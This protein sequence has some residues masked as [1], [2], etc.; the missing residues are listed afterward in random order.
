MSS[1]DPSIV[2]QAAEKKLAA[3]DLSGG[4]ELFQTSLFNWIDDV[5]FSSTIDK[6][7]LK[8]AV[9][10]LWV[11]Y[12][13]YLSKAK[14][15][16]SAINAFEDALKCPVGG[17]VGRVWLEYARFLEERGKLV[18]A[19]K[20]YLRALVDDGGAVTDEQDRNLLWQEFLEMM[21]TSKPD[22][23]MER[24]KQGIA[25][26]HGG[27]QPQSVTSAA[28]ADE[29]DVYGDLMPDAK[30]QRTGSPKIKQEDPNE[31]AQV[32]RTHVV[33][34]SDVK[35]EETALEDIIQNAKS[36]PQFLAAWM[37]RDG[38]APP[39]APQ[40]ML[41]DA[42]PPKL[43]DPTGKDLLGEDMAL[44]LVQR[45][46]SASGSVILQTCRG[47]WMMTA[48][49]EHLS[50]QKLKDMDESIKE[51]IVTLH[52]RL[53]ER[54]SVAGAAEAAVRS[55]NETEQTGFE[56]NCNQQRQQLLIS[57]AWDMRQLLWVQQQFLTK[58]KIPGFQGTTV[59]DV[60]LEYQGRICS[61]L[62]SA[63]FLRQRIGE[64]AHMKMLKSQE[65]KLKKILED[66]RAAGLSPKF[67]STG[68]RMTPPPMGGTLSPMRNSPVPQPQYPNMQP[69]PIQA[70]M[71]PMP[72]QAYNMP[73]GMPPLPQHYGGV[74]GM[75]YP[76]QMYA[77][78][79]QQ[80][81]HP[82]M[83]QPMMMNPNYPQQPL[84]QPPHGNPPYY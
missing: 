77:P 30:R 34:A 81:H 21:K 38:D 42:T 75:G 36:D 2:I 28:S 10:T 55:V 16:A 20:V 84:P 3:G 9:A 54:L 27:A 14:Q 6:D 32:S 18:K 48:L 35:T 45:L 41:F 33:T 79:Q 12:A 63:F 69:P 1:Y 64:E 23:T 60:E 4:Q 80:Y 73:P 67:G 40:I 39:Q 51:Q 44:K 56:A 59:D 46:L 71:L 52:Q 53:D 13:Q 7:T 17:Q 29:D 68:A 24:L 26:E 47:L 43:S 49:T 65:T 76:Q 8:E 57:I 25:E 82:Y 70:G 74:P 31:A 72:Q 58:L 78:Q 37:V 5:Q 19:Q 83:Q 50:T 66:A 11:S 22:L 62:H 61:Y 15:N